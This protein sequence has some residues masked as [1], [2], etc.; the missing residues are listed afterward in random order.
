MVYFDKYKYEKIDVENFAYF[1]PG[2]IIGHITKHVSIKS[3]H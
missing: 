3:W 1:D 2:S